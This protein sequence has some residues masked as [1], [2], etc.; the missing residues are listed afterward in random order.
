MQLQVL[1]ST[2]ILEKDKELE[3]PVMNPLTN[4]SISFF[5]WHIIKQI[6]KF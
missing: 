3:L 4:S 2:V 5:L 6:N 1:D